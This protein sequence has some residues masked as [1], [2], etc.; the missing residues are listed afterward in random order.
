[1]TPKEFN[2]A[3]GAVIR[4]YRKTHG[5]SQAVVGR[6]LGVTYQ[7]IQKSESGLNGF[8]A[9]Y[10][11][12]LAALFG[13][14]VNDL[15]TQAGAQVYAKPTAADNDVFMVSRY[16][17]KIRDERQRQAVVEFTRKLVYERA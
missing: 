1:M 15:Y 5:L 14:T 11:P 17:R 12:T 4:Q 2:K 10:F 9:H 3:M 6:A 8:C 16:L 13:V 7:Q